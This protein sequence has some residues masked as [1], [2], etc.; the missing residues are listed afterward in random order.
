MNVDI[1][2]TF[3]NALKLHMAGQPNE[4]EPLYRRILAVNPKH[5]D[6]LH[7]LGVVALD[8]GC[9]EE[10]LGL[11]GKAISM[12]DRVADFHCNMGLALSNVGR[13]QD[14]KS[15]RLNSSH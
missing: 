8:R 10:A 2:Q 1:N 14:R 5:V 7:L 13:T 3:N 12:N 11:I 9:H 4:A 15:T 6:S